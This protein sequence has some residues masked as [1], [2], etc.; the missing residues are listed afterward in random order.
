MIVTCDTVTDQSQSER[1]TDRQ[2]KKRESAKCKETNLR[3]REKKMKKGE[4]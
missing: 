3:D 4:R 1:K 2:Q